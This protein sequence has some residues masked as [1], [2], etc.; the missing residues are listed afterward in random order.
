MCV[1][2]CVCVIEKGEGF[3]LAFGLIKV[4][5]VV[6]HEQSQA[7]DTVSLDSHVTVTDIE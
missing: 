3:S 5:C 1:C 6:C 2:V 4:Q 7:K